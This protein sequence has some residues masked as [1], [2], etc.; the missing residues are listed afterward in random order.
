MKLDDKLMTQM[1]SDYK[2][3]ATHM[4]NVKEMK[5]KHISNQEAATHKKHRKNKNRN[6]K[7]RSMDTTTE[8]TEDAGDL[9]EDGSTTVNMT[10]SL[11]TIDNLNN[12]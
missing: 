3:Y 4:A 9:L 2:D 8:S 5:Q 6:K 12:T 10:S 11:Q 1:P 7:D